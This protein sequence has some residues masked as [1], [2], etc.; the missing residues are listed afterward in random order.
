MGHKPTDI[1]SSTQ[2]M[3]HFVSPS[4][5]MVRAYFWRKLAHINYFQPYQMVDEN[6]NVRNA[7]FCISDILQMIQGGIPQR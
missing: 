2:G 4:K 5:K 6:R 7:K 3:G 1:F